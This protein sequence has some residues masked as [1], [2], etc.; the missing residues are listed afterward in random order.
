MKEYIVIAKDE[1]SIDSIHTEL[2][3]NT[4]H[5]NTVDR[6][7]IPTRPVAVANS[8]LGNPR[9]T[10]YYLTDAEAQAL[11]KDPRIEAIHTMPAPDTKIKTVI[12]QSRS[13]NGVIGNFNRN[14]DTVD[15]YNINWG[16]RRTSLTTAET[17]IGNSY[18][19]E[20]DGSGVD[21]VIMDDGLQCDHPEF[22][23]VTG[24][25]RVHQINWYTAT[26]LDGKMPLNHYLCQN[27]GDGEHGTHVA[28]T[29][30]GKT[31]GYAKN[32]RIYLIRVFGD[33][34]QV[35][36]DADQFDLI[37]VWH[38]KK[39]VDPRTGA[40]RPTIVN[41]SWGYSWFYANGQHNLNRRNIKTINY[42]NKI[43]SYS[44]SPTSPRI[45]Y[46]QLLTSGG[47]HGFVVPSVNAEQ[48]DAENVGVIFVHAAGN[49][50]HKIDKLNGID[51]N[52]YYTTDD[53]WGGF[54]PPGYPIH[55][56]KGCSPFSSNCIT[57][58]AAR[59][60]AVFNKGT[61]KEVVDSYS[62]RGPGCDVVAPGTNITA[63][64]SKTS[65]Y[66]N[67]EY[68]WGQNNAQTR[69]YLV[70]KISGTSMAAPQ[71]TGVL[72]LYLSRNPTTTPA[73]A[74][75]WIAKIGIKNQIASSVVN[76][77]WS[78]PNALLGGP[79]NY[80]FNPYRNRYKDAK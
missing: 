53:V 67:L 35:I 64:V 17:R 4:L 65:S 33:S 42:R 76:N 24:V 51:W 38:S 48:Q 1:P 46:G 71:V 39:P 72:A 77:E 26:G 62:E 2:I 28:T 68:V 5:I 43:Y 9:I 44:N 57:V 22:V 15:K 8:R 79:N 70:A 60:R 16:L 29:A 45:E 36:P 32:A 40:K 61:I 12:Q 23:D 69:S 30:A 74:K 34:T 31:F 47:R 50:S 20:A 56:H 21:V 78:S 75:A 59:D 58:S 41:T 73:Q 25:S 54:V 7:V 11:E 3:Y 80:L 52:N 18:E 19:Y 27:Y 10:H 63:G 55:Y 49:Y 6:N 14:G 66:S 13:Y 37:R